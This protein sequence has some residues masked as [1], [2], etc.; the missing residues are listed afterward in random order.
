MKQFL[1]F[2]VFC[3][4]AFE[5]NYVWLRQIEL[6]REALK[7]KIGMWR[8]AM[9]EASINVKSPMILVIVKLTTN[10]E[11]ELVRDDT[12]VED[13]SLAFQ[14]SGKQISTWDDW[15][16]FDIT[17]TWISNKRNIS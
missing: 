10:D 3:S 17:F 16:L 14:P 7:W 2:S 11:R 13:P 4:S 8:Y 5:W 12:V 6:S 9:A 1:L 15:P